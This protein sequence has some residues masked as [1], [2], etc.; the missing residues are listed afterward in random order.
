M[1]PAEYHDRNSGAPHTELRGKLLTELVN[2][3]FLEERQLQDVSAHPNVEGLNDELES[4]LKLN[5]LGQQLAR[6]NL[7]RPSGQYVA[8][9]ERSRESR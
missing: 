2:T 7:V 4:V 8:G 6:G 1:S 5:H 3:G 9:L